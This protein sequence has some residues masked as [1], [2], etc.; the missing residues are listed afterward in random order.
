MS[1]SRRRVRA[2]RGA[3]AFFTALAMASASLGIPSGAHSGAA[4]PAASRAEVEPM[5]PAGPIAPAGP[6]APADDPAEDPLDEPR[7]EIVDLSSLIVQPGE[8]LAVDVSVVGPKNQDYPGDARPLVIQLRL[9][10]YVPSNTVALGQWLASPDGN[11]GYVVAKQVIEPL[12]AGEHRTVRLEVNSTSLPHRTTWQWGPRGLQAELFHGRSRIT[13]DRSVVTLSNGQRPGA[14]QPFALAIPLTPDVSDMRGADEFSAILEQLKT[15]DSPPITTPG[16]SHRDTGDDSDKDADG[17][18]PSPAKSPVATPSTSP[19]EQAD[20]DESHDDD[21]NIDAPASDAST[22]DSTNDSNTQPVANPD[23]AATLELIEAG[24]ASASLLADP[25]LI[26]QLIA[27]ADQ[28]NAQS[29]LMSALAQAR[30]TLLLPWADADVQAAAHAGVWD[31]VEHAKELSQQWRN[32]MAMAGWPLDDIAVHLAAPATPYFTP[33]LDQQVA[34]ALI[35]HSWRGAIVS[36]LDLPP[37]ST[38]NYTPSA[39]VDIPG[40]HGTLAAVIPDLRGSALLANLLWAPPRAGNWVNADQRE[41]S[42]QISSLDAAAM[43]VAHAAVIY[44]ERPSDPRPL[45]YAGARGAVNPHT[46]ARLSEAIEH[47]PWLN[48]VDL[49]T[50]LELPAGGHERLA[51]PER[52]T[53][54]GEFTAENAELASTLRESARTQSTIFTADA[55]LADAGSALADTYPSLAQRADPEARDREIAEADQ[56]LASLMHSI[57]VEPSSTLNLISAE[58]SLPVHIS[59]PLGVPVNVQVHLRP[60]DHR[61]RMIRPAEVTLAP[62]Q[63]TSV[64]IPVKAVGSGDLPVEVTL[65]APSGKEIGTPQTIKIRVRA[66]WEN[67]GTLIITAILVILFIIGT[68]RTI[69][70]G[71]RMT[72]QKLSGKAHGNR[73]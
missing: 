62:K 56:A 16:N 44:R 66:D 32:D 73:Q 69:R 42:T 53:H 47:A 11:P 72:P 50:M 40:T 38:I 5:V 7:I 9:Q 55:A 58:A 36:P 10:G 60:R 39:R 64:L 33:A 43:A 67:T 71:R 61:L 59:N 4:W 15:G 13:T 24:G 30:E 6:M 1:P 20:N 22:S 41:Q 37:A 3:A 25:F 52:L 34:D 21:A 26:S 46:L 18:T 65:A 23:L 63:S 70:R 27:G 12:A 51:L 2:R 17:E 57:T 14:P 48:V 8:N 68:V 19:V 54:P 49:S 45:L 35:A 29:A 28:S 31:V